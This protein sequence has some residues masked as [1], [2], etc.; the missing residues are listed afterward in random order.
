MN[1]TSSNS[2]LEPA[3]PTQ[4][5]AVYT[6]TFDEIVALIQTGQDI[7]GIRDIP[8][9]VLT[10]QGSTATTPA[11]RKPWER[12]AG[13]EESSAMVPTVAEVGAIGSNVAGQGEG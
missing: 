5:P 12:G 13:R 2:A 7:P 6:P 10:G 9:T 11:R 1:G 3:T 8:D 4:P